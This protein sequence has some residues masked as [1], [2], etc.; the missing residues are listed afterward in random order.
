MFNAKSPQCRNPFSRKAW[1]IG[2][3]DVSKARWRTFMKQW[4]NFLVLAA[5]AVAWT[6]CA[7]TQPRTHQR[8][9]VVEYLYPDK[10]PPAPR[11]DVPVLSL[12]L[13]VGIAFVPDLAS[14]PSAESALTEKQK[15]ELLDRVAENFRKHNFIRNVTVIP[16]QYLSPRGGFDNLEQVATMFGMDVV[17]L[18]SYDQIQF[19]DDHQLLTWSYL[20]LVGAYVVQGERN[21]THTM[22]DAAVFHIPSRRLLFRAPGISRIQRASTPVDLQVTRR[23]DRHAGFE[24]AARDLSVNLEKQ[25]NGFKE[26]VRKSPEQYTVV[27]RPGYSGLGAIDGWIIL[28]ALIMGGA[29][30]WRRA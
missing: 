17:A 19:T 4:I 24:R 5:L 10:R 1:P 15:V 8:A 6:G 7:W 3:E 14:G 13:E 25:L 11:P 23:Q 29:L 18:V 2:M 21:T 27:T 16:S 20:T 22:V 12:P 9:S 30:A 28:A 26:Q